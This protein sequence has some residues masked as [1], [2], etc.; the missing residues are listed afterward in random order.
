MKP[1]GRPDIPMEK[2]FGW[3]HK[4]GGAEYLGICKAGHPLLTRW[5]V[6]NMSPA[7]WVWGAGS[8]FRKGMMASAHL[9]ARHF[10]VSL[11]TNGA[12]QVAKP[13]LELR[14]SESEYVSLCGG[15]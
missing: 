8:R 5:M 1:E 3:A 6:A 13:V 2:Q 9:D 14:G 10:C 4:L 11:Y 12:F 15:L 7:C